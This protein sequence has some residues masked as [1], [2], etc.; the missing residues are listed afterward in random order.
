MTVS[1][2]QGVNGWQARDRYPD[3]PPRLM[4]KGTGGRRGLVGHLLGSA[5]VSECQSIVRVSV[6]SSESVNGCQRAVRAS[7]SSSV[8]GSGSVRFHRKLTGG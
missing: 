2:C 8:R 3:T 6:S 1:G 5:S 7:V 4:G